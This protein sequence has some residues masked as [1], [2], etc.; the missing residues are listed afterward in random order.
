MAT[1][2]KAKIFIAVVVDVPKVTISVIVENFIPSDENVTEAYLEK[3]I[4]AYGTARL[5]RHVPAK[6][7]F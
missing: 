2:A 6:E 5:T 7:D 1:T 3:M 4:S